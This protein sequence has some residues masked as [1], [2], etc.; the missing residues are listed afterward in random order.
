MEY[1]RIP[2]TLVGF[3]NTETEIRE[4]TT[5]R[6]MNLIK[7]YLNSRDEIHDC[8]NC[9]KRMHIHDNYE[10]N[11]RHLCL[12]KTLTCVRLNSQ[13]V[14]KILKLLGVFSN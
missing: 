1:I 11:L 14:Q 5:D 2:T 8:P 4:T 13:K 9:G 7:G 6:T 12:G 3:T 10:V